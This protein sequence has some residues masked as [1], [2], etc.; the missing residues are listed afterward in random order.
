[1]S[2]QEISTQSSPLYSYQ[3]VPMENGVAQGVSIPNYFPSCSSVVGTVSFLA[4]GVV[5]TK[6]Y[7]LPALPTV[8][9]TGGTAYIFSNSATDTSTYLFTWRNLTATSKYVSILPC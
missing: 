7:V 3:F 2:N 1:M 8:G 9:D 5:G 4:G 6:V